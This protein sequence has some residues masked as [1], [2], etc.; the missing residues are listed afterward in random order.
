M[1]IEVIAGL[2]HLSNG[3]ILRRAQAIQVPALISANC[4]SRW[5]TRRGWLEWLGWRLRPLANA[6]GL[7]SLRLDGAG[8]VTTRVYGE[9]FWTVAQY[10]ELAAAYP[11]E[12]FA[13][14]DYCTEHE[15]AHDREEVLDRVA[16]TIQ[17]NKECQL[18][19]ADLG[20]KNLLP[21]LQGRRPAD[22]E[23]CAD[24]LWFSMI[25]GTTV[26]VGSICR[27]EINGP[28]GLIAVVEH[29]DRVLPPGVAL[30]LFGVKGTALPY[31]LPFRDRV[32]SID[33]QAY[34]V[35]ARQEALRSGI[36]KTDAMVADHL[37]AWVLRQHQRLTEKPKRMAI[38]AAAAQTWRRLSP[39][40]KALA[41]ARSEI[42][43]LIEAGELDFRMVSARWVHDWALD[44]LQSNRE[45]A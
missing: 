8:F 10:L 17:V 36:S 20:L 21:V 37:E 22:Y 39:W 19:A 32:A 35:A 23:R 2:A 31:L 12:W 7:K 27:R 18:Q 26:G 13:S 38:Q 41:D 6:R 45:A 28:E 30:H 14:L 34:G 24:A 9:Y 15:I 5:S 4:L 16:R 33:S 11:F 29:L 40:E 43:D 25:P 44:N 42:R 3:P 1:T